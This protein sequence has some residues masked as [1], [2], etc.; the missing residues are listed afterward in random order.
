ML[1]EYPRSHRRRIRS[2]LK[3][4]FVVA[5]VVPVIQLDSGVTPRTVL[6]QEDLTYEDAMDKGR[7]MFRRGKYEDALKSFKRAND[8]RGKKSAEALM[9]MAQTYYGLEAYKNVVET[10][11]KVIAIPDAEVEFRAQ[12]LNYKG[13]GLQSLAEAKDQ[14]KLKEAE[15]AFREALALNVARLP[16][17]RHN[18]GIVL[19]Q[20]NRDAEGI[21]ELQEYLKAQPEGRY[22]EQARKMI[23]NPRRARE[24]YAPDFSVVTSDGE[25]I[26]LEDLRGKVVVLDFWGTW[27]PPCVASVPSLRALH[28]KFSK[29]PQFVLIGISSDHEEENWREFTSKE[30]MIWPQYLDRTR[31]VQRAFKVNVFPTYIVIDHEGIVRFRS[32]GTSW[33]RTASLTDVIKKHVKMVAKTDAANN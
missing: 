23:D 13:L 22:A 31:E 33:E 11:D 19:L 7:E 9:W 17:I 5:V 28:K 16:L 27:C 1:T 10:S 18:L 21:V 4:L 24:A 6:A 14:K 20:Q 32:S 30:K 29:E 15:A 3:I 2:F 26:S 25:H 12:A 8:L